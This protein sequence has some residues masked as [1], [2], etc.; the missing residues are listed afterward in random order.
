V[1]ISTSGRVT[2][3]RHIREATGLLPNTDVEFV[4]NGDVVYLVPAEARG[5]RTVATLRAR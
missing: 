1:R 3:P 2:I 5:L 4:Y